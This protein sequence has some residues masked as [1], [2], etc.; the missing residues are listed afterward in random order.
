MLLVWNL[1]AQ[2]HDTSAHICGP[3]F[4]YS[5]FMKGFLQFS[6]ARFLTLFRVLF[7]TIVSELLS[8]LY[9]WFILLA[10]AWERIC[11]VF[12]VLSL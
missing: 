9:P 12:S 8:W 6:P 10:F 1:A 2:N 7:P 4:I 3:S 11:S 5:S